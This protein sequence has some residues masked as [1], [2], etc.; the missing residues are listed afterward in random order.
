MT[1]ENVQLLTGQCHCGSVKYEARG[2]ILFQGTCTCRACQRATGTLASP[3][4]QVAPENVQITSGSVTRFK[5]DSDIACDA[6]VWHFCNQCGS[7]LFWKNAA[8]T[9]L[10]IMVGTLDDTSVFQPETR[11]T[12][13]T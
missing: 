1:V 2:P 3:N 11:Q 13:L 10:A 5:A 9:E 8:G 12:D 4:L 7:Q 6:G